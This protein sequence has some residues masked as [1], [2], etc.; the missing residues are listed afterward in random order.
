MPTTGEAQEIEAV[1]SSAIFSEA[2]L[3]ARL[4]KYLFINH[5]GEGKSS[6]NEYKIGVEA[7]GRP[8]NF[9]PATK[10]GVRVEM[11]RL[12]VRLRKYYETEGA[13]H[14]LKI[15][16]TEGHY[17]LQFVRSG[18]ASVAA[19]HGLEENEGPVAVQDGRLSRQDRAPLEFSTLAIPAVNPQKSRI[20]R[21]SPKV[22]AIAAT[23]LLALSVAVWVLV[24]TLSRQ[25]DAQASPARPATT[26]DATPDGSAQEGAIRVLVGYKKPR[27]IDRSGRIW[28]GD[29]FFTGGTV[30]TQT[31][32]FVQGTSDPGIYFS[33]R[34]GEFAYD[35]PV[36]PGVYELRLHF[37]ETELGIGTPQ[38]NGEGS[39][40]FTI[41]LNNNPLLSNLDVM[42]GAGGN[43]TAYTRVFKNISPTADGMIHLGTRH[44]MGEPILNA[45]EILP[46][47]HGKMN[48]LRITA[49]TEA[50]VD[51][52]GNTWDADNYSIGGVLATR[53][54]PGLVAEEP[55]LF[56][57][58]RFGAFRYQ[59]PVPDGKYKVTLFFAERYF[60]TA[61][62]AAETGGERIFDVYCNGEALLR[63]FNLLAR[64]GGPNR[65]ISMQFR[66]IQ[67]NAAGQIVL[68]SVPVKN[69]AVV[70][71]VEVEDESSE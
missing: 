21:F 18:D 44:Q 52:E 34:V 45:I 29:R 59:I 2:P 17:G 16:L 56:D 41:L 61:A 6:L 36:P 14:P 54:R 11:H 39:R 55:H 51:S 67:P 48:P 37:D 19:Q 58:E 40:I 26:L 33:E 27:Y 5:L 68:N 4:L 42:S 63:N 47:T 3:L 28:V 38:S 12:R 15:V 31:P 1:L 7:L 64:A 35:I 13:S 60:G 69:Y 9:D 57:G 50:F 20:R 66:G 46:E 70:N 25:R 23:A 22:I 10:S 65:G 43:N 71:A 53:V 24:G 8:E 30:R 32:P 49:Q 62:V